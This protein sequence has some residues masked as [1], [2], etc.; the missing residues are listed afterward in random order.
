MVKRVLQAAVAA[1]VLSI[2]P[3]TTARADATVCTGS[4]GLRRLRVRQ[5][6]AEHLFTTGELCFLHRRWKSTVG[7]NDG[8][9]SF[10]L[11]RPPVRSS[12]RTGHGR[13]AVTDFRGLMC[14][15]KD[16]PAATLRR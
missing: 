14:A 15:P 2:A 11:T 9:N 7:L 1:G 3:L 6:G 8:V 4:L 13:S 5:P 10:G 12:L 16:R